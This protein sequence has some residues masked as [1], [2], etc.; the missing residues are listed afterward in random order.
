MTNSIVAAIGAPPP[1][2]WV[3]PL[4]IGVLCLAGAAA[5][6]GALASWRLD[7]GQVADGAWWLLISGNFVHFGWGHFGLN[8]LGL[9]V[10]HLLIGR[11]LSPI[12]WL[13]TVLLSALVVG[14]GIYQFN[15]EI[16]WYS[17]LSG[18]LHGLFAAGAILTIRYDWVYGG[19]LLFGVV[20][21]LGWEQVYGPLDS[22]TAMIGARIAVDS[23]LYGAV[24]GLAAALVM[25]VVMA[26]RRR[27]WQAPGQQDPAEGPSQ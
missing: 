12:A 20:G 1:K 24:G 9:F 17:G 3:L 19:A 27:P 23:H 7:R 15:P 13:A 16:H 18:V 21:K 10:I 11:E 4:C 8:M 2:M 5:G 22:S 25:L 6:D 14:L 26:L